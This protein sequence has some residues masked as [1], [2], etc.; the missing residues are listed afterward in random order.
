MYEIRYR[1]ADDWPETV[2]VQ[3]RSMKG[4]ITKFEENFEETH[5]NITILS[6]TKSDMDI[7]N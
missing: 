3:A 6:V 2:L 7:I 5:N 4:A 1:I